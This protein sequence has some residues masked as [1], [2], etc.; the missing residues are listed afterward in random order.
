[1]EGRKNVTSDINNVS[2]LTKSEL[3]VYNLLK[4]NPNYTR[5]EIAAKINKTVRTVQRA[6]ETL[7]NK[8]YIVRIGTNR[9]GYWEIRK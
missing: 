7:K 8:E 4:E 5:D 3:A 1:M 9:A 6:L 2:L